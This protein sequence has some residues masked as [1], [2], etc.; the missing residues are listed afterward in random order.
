MGEKN[1]PNMLKSGEKR[2][3]ERKRLSW[4]EQETSTP[5][6]HCMDTNYLPIA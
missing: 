5:Q 2:E 1:E 4:V 3:R 6:T